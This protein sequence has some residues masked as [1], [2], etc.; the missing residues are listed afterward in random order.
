M[1]QFIVGCSKLQPSIKSVWEAHPHTFSQRRH[2]IHTPSGG[3]T[4][5][6]F[7]RHHAL[8]PRTAKSKARWKPPSLNGRRKTAWAEILQGNTIL[9]YPLKCFHAINKRKKPHYHIYY[10]S[11][12]LLIYCFVHLWFS[13][14]HISLMKCDF[15]KCFPELKEDR[16]LNLPT[17]INKC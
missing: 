10:Q 17:I 3:E 4:T 2:F 1:E 16:S 14:I 15:H 11:K 13:A 7:P 12:L 5:P 8:F 6:V 9:K